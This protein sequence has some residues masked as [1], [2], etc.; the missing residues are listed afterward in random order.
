[1]VCRWLERMV[2]NAWRQIRLL[3]LRGKC[4]VDYLA[5]ERSQKS[6]S[7]QLRGSNPLHLDV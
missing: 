6:A 7:G 4:G 3:T 2:A 5:I 1:M